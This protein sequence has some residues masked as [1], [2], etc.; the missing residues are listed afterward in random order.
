MSIQVFTQAGAGR[1]RRARR[2]VIAGILFAASVA[3]ISVKLLHGTAESPATGVRGYGSSERFQFHFEPNRLTKDQILEAQRLSESAWEN[4]S[5]FF[6]AAPPLVEINLTPNFLAF[7]G[8]T[9][10]RGSG[11]QRHPVIEIR[12]PDLEYLAVSPRQGIQH[13]MT[14]AFDESVTASPL[15]EGIADW[16]AGEYGN[17]KLRPWWGKALRNASLWIDP[18]ALFVT[19]GLRY[20][21]TPRVAYYAETAVLT[22][23]LVNRYGWH[24]V[25]GFAIDLK[26]APS[27]SSSVDASAATEN[28]RGPLVRS[29][30]AKW[31]G[32]EWPILEADW[33]ATI[34]DDPVP[35]RD[36]D[37]LIAGIRLYASA[38]VYERDLRKAH[39]TFDPDGQLRIRQAYLSASRS[40][41]EGDTPTVYSKL[42]EAERMRDKLLAQT[43]SS[44]MERQ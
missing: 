9:W 12:Y 36:G 37:A 3:V 34:N 26:T 40:L 23:Y 21:S 8:R 4:C 38:R 24:K 33:L 2:L 15:A 17:I 28:N 11:S 19:G 5:K 25:R 43:K 1:T 41:E 32:V 22:Q 20:S 27:I 6:G 10:W 13:E 39:P 44:G 29:M 18:E 7:T 14:H 35:A 42:G 31:F 30:V 16:F